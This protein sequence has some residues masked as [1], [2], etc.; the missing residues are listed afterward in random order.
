MRIAVVHPALGADEPREIFARAAKAGAAGAEVHYASAAIAS[1]LGDGEHAEQLRL[2]ADK[3]HVAIAGL[4]LDCLNAH[5]ALIGRPGVIETTHQLILRALGAAAA[6]GARN[7]TIPFF[8]KNAIELESEF[9]R[10]TDAL[11][12]MVDH[13]E[14]AGICLALETTLPCHQQENLL[15]HLGNS[16]YAKISCNTAVALSRKADVATAIRQLGAER[17]AQVRCRDVRI[18]EGMPPDYDVPLGEGDVDFHAVAQSLQAVGFEGWVIVDPPMPE[19]ASK[20]PVAAARKAVEFAR[21]LFEGAA[22]T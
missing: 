1:V 9:T 17:I 19:P 13:A 2:A 8:G 7:L 10:A 12:E 11:F 3:A 21:N 20:R 22:G 5:P 6:A 4:C 18:A 14:E 15:I 16:D